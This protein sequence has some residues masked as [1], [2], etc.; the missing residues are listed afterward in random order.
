MPAFLLVYIVEFH[1]ISISHKPTDGFT[2]Q[3][4]DFLNHDVQDVLVWNHDIGHKNIIF[5]LHVLRTVEILL[6]LMQ[7][8][9][10]ISF[11][12]FL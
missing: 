8:V 10:F 11:M 1:C 4:V 12:V 3:E 2:Y 6:F 9:M 7:K 5:V